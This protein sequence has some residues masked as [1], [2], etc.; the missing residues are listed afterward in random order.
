MNRCCICRADIDPETAPLLT[1]GGYGNPR[2]LCDDCARLMDEV[3]RGTEYSAIDTAMDELASRM[4]NA[5][6]DDRVVLNTVT[7]IFTAA[8]ER[9]EKIKEGTYDFA[10]DDSPIDGEDAPEDL[11]PELCETE[12]DRLL[13]EKEAN[14]SKKWD[15]VTNWVNL[16]ILLAA[17]GFLIWHFLR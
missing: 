3:M 5:D 7:S 1:L 14:T 16:G 10:L 2:Y 11:P 15:K 13:D 12:E 8:T 9:A 6:S 4:E 17:I